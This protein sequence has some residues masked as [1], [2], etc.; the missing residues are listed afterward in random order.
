MDRNSITGIVLIMG[1][2]IGYQFFF[3]PKE[4]PVV[5]TKAATQK[6]VTV[7]RKDSAKVVAIDSS[8]KK[9]QLF[10]LEN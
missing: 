8:V 9:E 6:T 10:T 3:A 7:A 5:K 2:L 4:I 1:M